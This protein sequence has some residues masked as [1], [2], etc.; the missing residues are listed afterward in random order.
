MLTAIHVPAHR[1]RA[2]FIKV[3]PRTGL[4]YG[5]GTVAAAVTG[6][7]RKPTSVRIVVGSV[8]SRPVPLTSAA[9]LIEQD[10]LTED[11]IEAAAEAARADLDEITNLYSS[12]GYKR[13][14]VRT[15]VRRSLGA[16]RR[17]KL[18]PGEVT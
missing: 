8:A 18:P 3:A 5:L 2:V 4:D 7:N 11:T 13:R 9:R 10:G 17:Q 14:L 12:A 6:S 15:L 1:H 16:L